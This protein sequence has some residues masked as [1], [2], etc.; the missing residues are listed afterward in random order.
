MCSV[1]MPVNVSGSEARGYIA[2][3]I[4][5]MKDV[6]YFIS[7]E[8]KNGDLEMIEDEE[9]PL[10]P[11]PPNKNIVIQL[12]PRKKKFELIG[13]NRER[14]EAIIDLTMPMK[15]NMKNII[16]KDPDRYTL[17]YKL[18][19]EQD[20][21]RL[22]CPDMSLTE[23]GWHNETL[24]IVRMV[25]PGD[26]ETCSNPDFIKDLYQNCLFAVRHKLSLYD[27]HLWGNLAI[28]KFVADGGDTSRFLRSDLDEVIPDIMRGDEVVQREALAALMKYKIATPPVACREYVSL[29]AQS[30]LQCCYIERM[31]FKVLGGGFLTLRRHAFVYF[32]YGRIAVTKQFCGKIWLSKARSD[33]E[34]I[35]DDDRFMFI[36]FKDATKWR[37]L[38]K[39]KQIVQRM[40]KYFGNICEEEAQIQE[41]VQGNIASTLRRCSSRTDDDFPSLFVQPEPAMKQER[42]PAYIVRV[43]PG[44]SELILPTDGEANIPIDM[45]SQ[46]YRRLQ[47]VEPLACVPSPFPDSNV[48]I[49]SSGCANPIRIGYVLLAI[50]ALVAISRVL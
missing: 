2:S 19:N 4:P 18:A 7:Q 43:E 47:V 46:I 28:L 40:L 44:I 39:S 36:E 29:C 42:L 35:T 26:V 22:V 45:D 50:A 41:H 48:A 31:K 49:S 15:Q 32:S 20:L 24:Y 37:L 27:E 34:N 1:K 13:C 3:S 14:I 33:I 38:P 11:I 8:R 9:K 23:Q 21:P 17:F 12:T 30:S 25:T 10:V 5:Q 16:S 6:D